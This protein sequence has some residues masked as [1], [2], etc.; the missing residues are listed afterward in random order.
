MNSDFKLFLKFLFSPI[1]SLGRIGFLLGNIITL[2]YVGL[3]IVLLDRLMQC[4]D[5]IF[6]YNL[7]FIILGCMCFAFIL[8]GVYSLFC[9]SL[10]RLFH[11][12]CSAPLA[13]LLLIAA[14]IFPW[15]HMVTSLFL[16]LWPGAK[17]TTTKQTLSKNVERDAPAPLRQF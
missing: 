10:K 2:L 11:L 15:L 8:V 5:F 9:L 6:H 4:E 3:I 17:S 13:V 7:L 14:L 1:G 12:Q 16:L